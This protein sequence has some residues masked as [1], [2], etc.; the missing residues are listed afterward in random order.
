MMETRDD[1][2]NRGAVAWLADRLA[3]ARILV[4][5]PQC[6][7][8]TSMCRTACAACWEAA[9]TSAAWARIEALDKAE[10]AAEAKAWGRN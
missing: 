10:A 5:H 8:C 3:G 2:I 4:E 9:A 7:S 6:V 1:R